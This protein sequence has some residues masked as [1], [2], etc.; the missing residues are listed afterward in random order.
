MG[1]HDQ[2][3]RSGVAEQRWMKLP[4]VVFC[5]ALLQ[6]ALMLGL[7]VCVFFF[8]PLVCAKEERKGSWL[9]RLLVL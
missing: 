8:F 7:L 1:C 5:C 9:G 4:H 6:V 3:G 2:P